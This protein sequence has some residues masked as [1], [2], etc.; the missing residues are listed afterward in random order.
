[1]TRVNRKYEYEYTRRVSK[2]IFDVMIGKQIPII[3]SIKQK[4]IENE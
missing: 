2:Y 4:K 3:D 1:M